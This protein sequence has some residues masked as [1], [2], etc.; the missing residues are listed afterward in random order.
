M[1]IAVITG[2]SKG[3][4]E[5]VAES[6][7]GRGVHIIGVSRSDNEKLNQKAEENGVSY[8]HYPCDLS[9][10][11]ELESV[12]SRINQHVKEQSPQKVYVVNNAGVVEPIDRV[13]AL[14]ANQVVKHVHINLIAPMLVTNMVVEQL[15]DIDVDIINVTSG[16]AN[17]PVYG[18]STY[19]GTKAGLNYFTETTAF[20]QKQRGG[21]HRTVAFSPGVMDTDMQADI[22]SSSEEAFADVEK[23]KAL[24]EEGKLRSPSVVADGLMKLLDEGFESGAVYRVDQLID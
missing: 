16:A 24:K 2:V 14:D 9:S 18:W 15:A 4:G 17:R 1:K 20:E 7:M 10:Q 5:S 22:R 8:T 11:E 23:F 12:F 6:M 19:G 13:G 21:K 3:L